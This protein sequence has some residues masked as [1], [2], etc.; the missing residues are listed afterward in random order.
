MGKKGVKKGYKTRYAGS[1][2]RGVVVTL[3][4]DPRK[5]VCDACGKSKHDGEIKNTALHHW[6]YKY[7]PATV[8]ENPFLALENTSE[9]CYYCHQLAHAVRALIY[10]KPS[11]VDDVAQLLEGEYK[12]R[13]LKV[14]VAVVESLRK[15]EKNIN[16]LA[17]RLLEMVRDGDKK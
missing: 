17:N 15:T 1:R 16:P 7:K 14:L 13:F 2:G 5:G 9:L 10:A 3:P 4:E 6:W 11:R 8:K 12:Q